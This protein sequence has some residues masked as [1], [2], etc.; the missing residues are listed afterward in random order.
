MAQGPTKSNV[1]DLRTVAQNHRDS[2]QEIERQKNALA[3]TVAM[4]Q[5]QNSGVLMQE[6]A[7][8]HE[9][10]EEKVTEMLW[11]FQDMADALENAANMIEQQDQAGGQALAGVAR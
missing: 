1:S 2:A 8:V 7:K 9:A 11:N 10:W 4:L 5:A 3:D 6:L